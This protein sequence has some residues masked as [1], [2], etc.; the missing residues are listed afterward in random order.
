MPRAAAKLMTRT[1]REEFR[2]AI[3]RAA[4]PCFLER[5]IAD[6]SLQE[7][8]DALGVSFWAVYRQYATRELLYREAVEPL[9]AELAAAAARLP[10]E[11]TSVNAAVS[12]CVRHTVA[13]MQTPR[14][15]DIVFLMLRDGA[16]QPWLHPTYR[17]TIVA[18]L[19]RGL[20]SSVR[21]A[22]DR[23]ALVIGIRPGVA[24]RALRMLEG[25]VVMPRL[26]PGSL[27]LLDDELAAAR[28]AATNLL[29]AGTYAVEFGTP[30]AA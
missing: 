28:S 27:P 24:D 8:A 26:L 9:F 14:Y 30:A 22:G 5:S 19:V 25:A 4:L 15:R 11:T 13:M 16:L 20:E 6:V 2:A 1:Q 3:R 12:A 18:P 10:R 7:I 17:Q 29:M 21:H 23:H